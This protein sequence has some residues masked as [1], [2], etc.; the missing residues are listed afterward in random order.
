MNSIA[1]YNF[2]G[3]VGKTTTTLNLG[4]SWSK[5]YKVLLID[6]DPQCNLTNALGKSESKN[7]VHTYVKGLLHHHDVHLP[8]QTVKPYLDII[9]GDYKMAEIETNHQFISFGEEMIRKLLV[10]VKSEYDVV[11]ID[12]PTNFGVL[13]KAILTSSQ[14]VLIPSVADSFSK[15]GIDRL[16]SFLS[17]IQKEK[18][19]NVLGVFC[20]MFNPNNNYAKKNLE[21]LKQHYGA[22]VLDE[23]ISK[24]VHVREANEAGLQIEQLSDTATIAKEFD[25]LSEALLDRLNGNY[26]VNDYSV[27]NG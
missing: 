9:S 26:L 1:I 27:T 8:I 11:L 22:L 13:V 12:C 3:G 23:T 6:M 2:K 19:L 17:D 20:N 4:H 15:T 24:S 5:T 21:L 14:K 10:T 25:Q 16:F 18:T 7:T